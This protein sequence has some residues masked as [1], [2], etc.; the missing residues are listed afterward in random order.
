MTAFRWWLAKRLNALCW[1]VTPKK[2]RAMLEGAW[3]TV[4]DDWIN[5]M[6]RQSRA[7]IEE[8]ER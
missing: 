2:N 1:I 3:S 5:D 4:K 6:V 8:R 7:K